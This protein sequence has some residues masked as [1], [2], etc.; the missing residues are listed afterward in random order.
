MK[1]NDLF[2]LTAE[3]PHDRCNAILFDLTQSSQELFIGPNW[4]QPIEE[5][6]LP[7]DFNATLSKINRI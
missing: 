7:R 5:R 6:Q 1:N 4:M 3:Q 2:T